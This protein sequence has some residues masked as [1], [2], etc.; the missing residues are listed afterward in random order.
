MM[1]L[2]QAITMKRLLKMISMNN[3]L[4]INNLNKS[5]H[6]I[7]G[8]I[9]AIKNISLNVKESEFISIIGPSGCGKS[10]ILNAIAGLD[11]YKGKIKFKKDKP[12]IGYML[13]SDSLFPWLTILD[14]ALIGL[15]IKK[16]LTKDNIDYTKSLLIK[17]GLKDF[18]NKYPS[19]LSGGMK[20]RVL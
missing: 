9:E 7:N 2:H 18:L 15:K 14:N 20:Q 16:I 17:Y 5:Y 1:R 10:T 13:Q 11:E 12:V 3:V 6:S 8:S 4:E 19:D